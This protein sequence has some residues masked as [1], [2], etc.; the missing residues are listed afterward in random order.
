MVAAGGTVSHSRCR[1]FQK[2]N[3]FATRVAVEGA[4]QTGEAGGRTSRVI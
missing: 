1:P 3:V 2:A 4:H